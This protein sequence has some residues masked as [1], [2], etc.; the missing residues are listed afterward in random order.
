M[1]EPERTPPARSTWRWAVI[2]ASVA[3]LL[4][5]FGYTAGW[6]APHRLTPQRIVDALQRNAGLH[7]GYRRNHAKGICVTG[8]FDSSGNASAYSRAI[9]FAPGRT[10][11][12][13][14]FAIPG[15]NPGAPDGGTP[16]RSL[17]LRFDLAN[18]QQ[19]RT[20]MN[21]SPVFPVATPQSFYEQLVASRPDPAT[22]HPDPLKL[23]AFYAAHP[24]TGAFRAWAKET[25]P[26]SSYVTESYY[27]LDAFYLID[28]GGK[29]HA[30]RW[31]AVPEAAAGASEMASA[32]APD[33]LAGD[34][35]QRLANGPL[36]WRLMLTLAAPG[37]PTNDATRAWPPDRHIIDA[38][39]L[40]IEHVQ[41]QDNGPCRDINYD[42]TVLPDGIVV[43]DDPLLAARSAAYA[44]SYLRRTSEHA[45]VPG[46]TRVER[47][48]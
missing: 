25:T 32:T 11:V 1:L 3:V 19:W 16:V 26:S 24:E 21:N 10:P 33:V 31:S 37:D 39:T 47:Q 6:L 12:V 2:A 40:V 23:A 20:G 42:P 44:N 45:G 27:G 41:P 34:L 7:P 14:R 15:G 8:Y 18:G 9:V 17:A 30:V 5:L 29:R 36:R 46:A 35:Q 38:G 28:A 4:L 48:P 22:G 13:G 43:S